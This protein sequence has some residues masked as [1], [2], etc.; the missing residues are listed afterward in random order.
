M[1]N[2]RIADGINLLSSSISELQGLKNSQTEEEHM[3]LK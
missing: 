3:E 2:L 1:N